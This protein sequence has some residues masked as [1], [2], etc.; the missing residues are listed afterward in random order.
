M[1]ELMQQRYPIYAEADVVV[2]SRDVAHEVIVDEILDRLADGPF[3]LAPE[4]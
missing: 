2:E 4:R 1:Q 3:A